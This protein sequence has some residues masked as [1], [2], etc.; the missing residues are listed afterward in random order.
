MANK[1]HERNKKAEATNSEIAWK[2][3]SDREREQRKNSLK[4]ENKWNKV[5]WRQHL[6]VRVRF[7]SIH[8]E[9][10]SAFCVPTIRWDFMFISLHSITTLCSLADNQHCCPCCA[11]PSPLLLLFISSDLMLRCHSG[12]GTE[13]RCRNANYEWNEA[14]EW[15]NV[16]MKDWLNWGHDCRGGQ[17]VIWAS[18]LRFLPRHDKWQTFGLGSS[19]PP[20]AIIYVN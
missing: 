4:I 15:L 1:W 5:I 18:L 12:Y 3:E 20:Y 8:C 6:C 10:F 9:C 17:R 14:N 19:Y 7:L 11:V 16:R 13:C 2:E